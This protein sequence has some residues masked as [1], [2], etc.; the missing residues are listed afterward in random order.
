MIYRQ[1]YSHFVHDGSFFI[2]CL[3]IVGFTYTWLCQSHSTIVF[4]RG[5]EAQHNRD[6]SPG[7]RLTVA[8]RIGGALPYYDVT[9]EYL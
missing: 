3:N 4:G 7:K 8:W 9:K 5:N 6:K 2:F 1:V